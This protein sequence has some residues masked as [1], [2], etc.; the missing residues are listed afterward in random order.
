MNTTRTRLQNVNAARWSLNGDSIGTVDLT[1]AANVPFGA[2]VYASRLS[3]YYWWD[4][5][6][7]L[8]TWYAFWEVNAILTAPK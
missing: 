3:D 4:N 5:H 7:P 6:R 2:N 1:D 8:P